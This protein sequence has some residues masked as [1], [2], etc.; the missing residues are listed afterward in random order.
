MFVCVFVCLQL[1][2]TVLSQSAKAKEHL[3]EQSKS[4]DQPAGR[5]GGTVTTPAVKGVCVSLSLG[6]EM[7]PS[8]P[9]SWIR[10]TIVTIRWSF[11]NVSV[12]NTH[13]Y[14]HRTWLV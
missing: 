6:E 13:L 3:M 2:A 5:A 10:K 12:S 8:E 7:K 1:L 14:T 4:V 9:E 11:K